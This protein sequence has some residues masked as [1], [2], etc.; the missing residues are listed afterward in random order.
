MKNKLKIIWQ[1]IHLSET[2]HENENVYSCNIWKKLYDFY[3]LFVGKGAS[4]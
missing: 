3:D 2:S 4:D 1:N